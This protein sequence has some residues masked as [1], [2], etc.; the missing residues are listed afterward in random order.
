M[1][2]YR[3]GPP[4][5]TRIARSLLPLVLGF[6]LDS[7]CLSLAADVSLRVHEIARPGGAQ[8]GQT[9]A[10]DVDRDGDLDFI[11]GRQGGTVFW[12]EQQGPDHWMHAQDR[13]SRPDRRRRRGDGCRRRWLDRPGLRRDLVPQPRQPA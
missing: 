4:R 11:S 6:L 13:R 9:S 12:F 2:T 10:V 1:H 8:L 3:S 7:S 5:L